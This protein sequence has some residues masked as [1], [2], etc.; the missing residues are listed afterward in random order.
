MFFISSSTPVLTS[1]IDVVFVLFI[2]LHLFEKLTLSI[3]IAFHIVLDVT[4]GIFDTFSRQ[5]NE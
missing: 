3:S 2:E 4:S 1:F 5:S